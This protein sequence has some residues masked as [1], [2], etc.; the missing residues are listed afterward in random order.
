MAQLDCSHRRVDY[1]RRGQF[2]VLSRF[3]SEF[4][5]RQMPQSRLLFCQNQKPHVR[6]HVHSR[7]VKHVYLHFA[8]V[9]RLSSETFMERK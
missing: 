8:T 6:H 1:D 3:Q 7:G 4:V 5:R 2:Y 9:R